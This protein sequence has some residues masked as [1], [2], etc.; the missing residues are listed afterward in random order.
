EK[1]LEETIQSVINQ[2]Y[3]NVEYVIIDGGSTDK[4]VSIINKYEN[5][6]DYWVSEKDKGIYDAMNKG[7]Y[8]SFGKGRLF[9]NAGDKFVGDILY[10]YLEIPSF[11]TVKYK[12]FGKLVTLKPKPIQK[13]LPYCHQGILF[14]RDNI[15]LYDTIYKYA[16]DYEYF[17]KKYKWKLNKFT[18]YSFNDSS[19]VY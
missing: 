18:L 5:Y 15:F 19:F 11:L 3:P 9:L 14:D 1:Y 10:P 12:R 6:I 13:G 17:I 8:L 2:T 16:A 7:I 4:T